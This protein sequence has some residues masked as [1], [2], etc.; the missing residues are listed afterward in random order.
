MSND[1]LDDLLDGTLDDLADIP[2]FKPYP[3]GVHQT[4]IFFEEKKVNNHP[5]VEVI[6]KFIESIELAN[7][8]KDTV[9]AKG[10]EA[11]VLYMM[12]NDLGQGKFKELMR[13]FAEANPG[14]KLRA[15]MKECSGNEVLVVTSQRPNK[16]K[17]KMYMDITEL[18]IV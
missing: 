6:L 5:C 9:P 10:S 11:S 2:E 8:E 16:E 1:K 18:K 17:T 12:D 13:P 4:Q 15:L 7:P 14:N 3:D